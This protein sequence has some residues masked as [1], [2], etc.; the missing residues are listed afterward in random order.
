MVHEPGR[1]GCSVCLYICVYVHVYIYI[2]ICVYLWVFFALL[3]YYVMLFGMYFNSTFG[4]WR[5]VILVLCVTC[6]MVGLTIKFT[7]PLPLWSGLKNDSCGSRSTKVTVWESRTFLN[8]GYVQRG[9]GCTAL[10][11]QSPFTLCI[12]PTIKAFILISVKPQSL[13]RQAIDVKGQSDQ[14]KTDG[15][16]GNGEGREGAGIG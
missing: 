4:G 13:Q 14:L 12:H 16:K 6:C 8:W 11:D 3:G 15:R 10:E 5:N 2:Y 1:C 7:L 9:L